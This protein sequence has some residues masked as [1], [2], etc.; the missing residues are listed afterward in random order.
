VV[1][2]Q[3]VS[4]ELLSCTVSSLK[5]GVAGHSAFMSHLT[6]THSVCK[7]FLRR[8]DLAI[9]SSNR[10]KSL[11]IIQI[12]SNNDGHKEKLSSPLPSC[13]PHRAKHRSE[14]CTCKFRRLGVLLYFCPL[15]HLTFCHRTKSFSFDAKDHWRVCGL[16]RRQP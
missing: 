12:R 11:T 14:C 4:D 1:P 9:S 8:K 2:L 3:V 7:G 15:T 5:Y 6:C 16:C 10:N 13:F